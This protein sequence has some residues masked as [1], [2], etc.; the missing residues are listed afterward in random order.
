M[1]SLADLSQSETNRMVGPWGDL[2]LAEFKLPR[3]P[4]LARLRWRLTLCTNL[5]NGI[6]CPSAVES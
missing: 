1:T 2:I 5:S 3:V 4:L 6:S